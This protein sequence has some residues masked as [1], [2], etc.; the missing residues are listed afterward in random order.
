[1]H[2]EDGR[3]PNSHSCT[4][5][6]ASSQYYTQS[7]MPARGPTED[8]PDGIP[9]EPSP[10][11]APPGRD[12]AY[13]LI[14]PLSPVLAVEL[15][16]IWFETFHPWFPILHQPSLSEKLGTSSSLKQCSHYLTIKAIA[17]VTLPHSRSML[18][19]T[20]ELR[21]YSKRLRDQVL[22]E[23]VEQSS[24]QSVQAL[25]ILSN[26]E[27]GEGRSSKFWSLIA[28]CKR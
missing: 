5:S 21:K 11:T 7:T 24:L 28:L 23:A 17:A 18:A 8:A 6:T 15:C 20:S 25:L 22:L 26:L 14:D 10:I 3:R 4:P 2:L 9:H 16:G 12:Q 27:C 13:A 1:M 19:T